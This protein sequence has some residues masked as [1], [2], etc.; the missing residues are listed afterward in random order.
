M[1]LFAGLKLPEM[2]TLYKD[3]FAYVEFVEKSIGYDSKESVPWL[4]DEF[5]FRDAN[6]AAWVME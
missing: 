5:G 4:Y 3:I 1:T 6:A 2:E